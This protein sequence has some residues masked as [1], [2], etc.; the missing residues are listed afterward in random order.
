MDNDLLLAVII[1]LGSVLLLTTAYMEW[2]GLVNASLRQ[3]DNI[4]PRRVRLE[5][6]YQA[7]F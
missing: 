5:Q 1:A 4:I 3:T 2:I 7:A 6:L